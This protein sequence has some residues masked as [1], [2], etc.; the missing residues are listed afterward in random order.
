MSGKEKSKLPFEGK[1][2]RQKKRLK[3][4]FSDITD[5]DLEFEPGSMDKM[6]EKLKVKLG[7]SR[8]EMH[9]VIE[10]LSQIL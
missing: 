2:I 6:F 8:E 7:K 10:Y 3:Q 5:Q 9:K 1:W 4:K